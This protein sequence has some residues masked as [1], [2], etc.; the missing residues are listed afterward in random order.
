LSHSS[1]D[2]RLQAAR[3]LDAAGIT[4]A[5]VPLRDVVSALNLELVQRRRDPFASEAAL[6]SR[7]DGHA[8]VLN[9]ASG[10]RR[11]RFTIAHE[12]GH[13]VLHP[14]RQRAERGGAVNSGMRS[15]E[16]EADRFAAELLM[17]EHLVRHAVVQVG[18]DVGRLAER[19]E[20][21]EAAMR[22]RLSRLGLL[23]RQNDLLPPSYGQL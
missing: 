7:G 10:E 4:A 9:G 18:A 2:I 12:I 6:E 13:F 15:Q 14:E 23:E 16:R 19:F 8:I 11:R 22:V 1:A 3:L 20:V 21:S 17:P 5:P